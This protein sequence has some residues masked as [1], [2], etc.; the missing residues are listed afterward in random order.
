[1]IRAR[2]RRPAPGISI[3]AL[4][5]ATACLVV[6]S[7]QI[8]RSAESAVVFMYHRFGEDTYP[9][10]NIRIEQFEAHLQE[11]RSGKVNVLGLPEIVAALRGRKKLPERT[12]GISIDDAFKSV[13]TEAW[14]RLRAAGLPFTVFVATDQVDRA[15]PGYMTWEQIRELARNG[16]TIGGHT[17]SHLHMAASSPARVAAELEKANERFKKELGKMPEL[18]AYPFGETGLAERKQVVDTGFVAAFGQHSGVLHGDRDFYYLPRFAMNESYGNV[19]RFRL[20]A[21]ALPLRVREITPADP[22]L[23]PGGNPPPFGFT[24]IGDAMKSLRTLACY[25]SDQ[26]KARIERLGEGR[27][28]VR[29]RRGFPAGRARINCTMPA[30]KGRWYWFGMQFYIPKG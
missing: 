18:F 7:T 11:Y 20:A 13:Y 23:S 19:S 5:V 16:V 2:H 26:G 25:T 15:A 3:T 12:V 8:A 1:M 4:F 9:A 27:I 30:G 28:E 22:K 10:T 6:A 17:A 14:P 24:V 29:L 21:G